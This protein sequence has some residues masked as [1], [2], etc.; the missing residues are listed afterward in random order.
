QLEVGRQLDRGGG[1]GL[2]TQAAEDAAREVDTEELR[3][4]ATILGLGLLQGN[5]THRASGR[6]QVAGNAALLAVRVT[7]Q[8]DATAITGRQ[9]HRLLRILQGV[10]LAESVAEDHYQAAQLGVGAMDDM[11]D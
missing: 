3:I 8:H 9:G 11:N 7:G 1:A 6:A 10:P 4:P 2:L 5:T